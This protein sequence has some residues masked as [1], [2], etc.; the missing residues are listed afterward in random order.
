ARLWQELLDVPRVGRHDHFFE[1]G[2]HSLLAVTMVERLRYEGWGAEVRALFTEPV[3]AAYAATLA[4]AAPEQSQRLQGIPSGTTR[5]TPDLL[6]LVD[7]TQPQL[8]RIVETVPGGAANIQDIC[9]LL[10]MQTGMLFHHLLERDGDPYLSCTVIGFSQRERLDD[11]VRIFDRLIARHD[12]L[13]IS[14]AW[15][16][17]AQPV[18]VIWREAHLPV[19]ELEVPVGED[20]LAMLSAHTDSRRLQLNL[21]SAPLLSAYVVHDQS[22][23]EWLLGFVSHHLIVDHRSLE[24]LMGELHQLLRDEAAV[25]PPSLPLREQ[26]AAAVAIPTEAHESY[27]REQLGDVDESTAPFGILDVQ[28]RAGALVI[29]Q[30]Y[31][32][33]ERARRMRE[34]ARQQQVSPAVLLHVAYALLL[35]SCSGRD[36]VVFGTVL[37]GRMHGAKGAN[38]ALGMFVNTLPLRVRLAGANAHALL[39]DCYRELTQLLAHEQAPLALAQRMSGLPADRPLFTAL[40]NYRHNATK[41]SVPA[42]D[43]MAGLRFVAGYGDHANYPL[44]L[45]INDFGD[46]FSLTAECVDGIDPVRVLD[47]LERAVDGLLHALESDGAIGNFSI[48]SEAEQR[49]QVEGFNDTRRDYPRD[50][51]LHEQ[52]AL[53]AAEQPEAVALEC[54]GERL[55]YRE[56]DER[57]NVLAHYL[58]GLGVGPDKRVAIVLPRGIEMVL[59]MLAVL[60]AGGAYVPLDPQQ[61]RE[62]LAW[63]LADTAPSAV[64]S[65]SDWEDC[66]PALDVPILRFD[67]EC[68][69]LLQR[70]APG[71]SAAP[72][73]PAL[74]A[75]HL[76]YVMYTS[77]STGQP[78]GV[79]VEHRQVLRL[80]INNHYCTLTAEDTVA[81][82][83]NPAF[84]AA[85]WEIWG[86]LLV[87]ARV[88]I[89]P[90][91]DLMVPARLVVCLRTSGVSAAWF[92]VGLFNQYEAALRPIFGQL[93]YLLV[94]GDAL[95]PAVMARVM[96]ASERPLHVVNGY[97]PTESTTFACTHELDASD[98]DGSPIPIG[99]PIANTRIYILGTKGEVL[100][101]GAT[102]EIFIGGDGVARGYW[103][104]PE[105]T[106][107]RFL[108]DP[109]V[110]GAR[111]YR[112]GDRGR[113]R[114]DGTLEY[115][116]RADGQVKI[117]GFRVE[118]GEVEAAL[119]AFPEIDD[120]AVLVH[121]LEGGDKSL[122]AY[123]VPTDTHGTQEQTQVWREA[124]S[125]SLPDYML[126]SIFV[127][128]PAMPLNA[129]GKL[130]RHALPSPEAGLRAARAYSPPIGETELALAAIWQQLLDVPQVGRDDDFFALGGHSLLAV[131]LSVHVQERFN[132]DLQLKTVFQKARLEDLA[133]AIEAAQL[134][135]PSEKD[136][137]DM[138]AELDALS[139]EELQAFLK[140]A[141][142]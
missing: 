47:Y 125:R 113:Y 70:P 48:L 104:Q 73:V 126:P 5:I 97:G 4:P 108:P 59:G 101:I 89:V 94:G 84:D 31:L 25:L 51:L 105:Q 42:D 63:M 71:T 122:V 118:T 54:D 9:P 115:L 96:N 78:K 38:T 8:D 130:N 43:G 82:A 121:A 26:V 75:D 14:L 60:K 88:V 58:T 67:V 140:D 77:G 99:R 34:L 50:S 116:G 124:L 114:A 37:A 81:H 133:Q 137:S 55:C 117:R 40:L 29:E 85:T 74:R 23:G 112:S 46:D 139:D 7:F 6:P 1:L 131:T 80:A 132:V 119:R 53:R 120:A 45:K 21:K 107:E 22:S 134:A 92:S 11:F 57:A 61:P 36:D 91:D 20:A 32:A 98:M 111:M 93:R 39:Q 68:N 16:G 123:V 17:L 49:Q 27:F 10:P 65:S 3:L 15:E 24:L 136:L 83:A 79:M 129:N 19:H 100:P 90:Q 141:E 69:A 128:L 106:R 28:Q 30:R 72:M 33:P 110:P 142:P 13:R 56:L 138:Q 41:D 109:F 18:Q 12:I 52:F 103:N 44:T 66:L 87:G 127:L 135:L 76:C 102:G 2:G 95:D 35:G 64:L 86:T 62:R